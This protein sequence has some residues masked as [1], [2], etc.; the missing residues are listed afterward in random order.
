MDTLTI[1]ST[2]MPMIW[3]RKDANG[4]VAK[5]EQTQDERLT[6]VVPPMGEYTVL[7]R[8]VAEPFE[9]TFDG[10]ASKK[11]RLELVIQNDGPG[12][13]KVCTILL[14]W[15][16][17]PKSYLGKIYQTVTGETVTQNAQY[18]VTRIIGHTF[19]A[20][21]MPSASTDDNGRPKGTNVVWDT[22]DALNAKTVPADGATATTDLWATQ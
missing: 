17:G 7:I 1:T 19:R 2:G 13:G 14:G 22:F 4:N 18:D 6:H 11:T 9:M 5:R 15:S 3:Y 20:M 10:K 21:L 16:I 8:G 12:K